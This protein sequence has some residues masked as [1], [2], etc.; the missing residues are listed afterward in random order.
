[1]ARV[2]LAHLTFPTDADALHVYNQVKAVMTN[3]SVAHIGEAGE[4]TSYC[5]MMV[6]QPDGTL[7]PDGNKTLHID[8]FGIVREGP[9]DNGNPPAWIQPTGAQ[10]AYPLTDVR[11][12]PTRVAYNGGTWVNTS[13]ANT[14]AP[15]VFGWS[16]E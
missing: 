5:N 4:R 12:N 15:G 1:M 9:Y 10:D 11:G 6:E 2:I 8:T 14:F 7:L 13:A 16:Q 3:S